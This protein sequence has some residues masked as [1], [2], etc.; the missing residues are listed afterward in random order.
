MRR[1][2]GAG[3]VRIHWWDLGVSEGENQI[4]CSSTL[5]VTGCLLLSIQ[6]L[7]HKPIKYQ[8]LVELMQ[9]RIPL[10]RALS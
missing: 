8:D 6:A 4:M 9:E 3:Q 5:V 1:T 7:T 10:V 2:V